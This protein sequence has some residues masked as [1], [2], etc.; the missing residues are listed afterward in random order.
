MSDTLRKNSN[1]IPPVVSHMIKIGEESGEI[2]SVLLHIARF[3]DQETEMT[4]KNLST[5][6]EPFLM[7]IIGFAVGFM[8]VAILLP[9]YNV[10]QN[11]R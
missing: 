1:F 3:Y 6:I 4:T 2:D 5:L 8:A 7:I 10:A 9:I 11:I